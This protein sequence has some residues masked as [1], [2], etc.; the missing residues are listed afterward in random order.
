MSSI[1]AQWPCDSWIL[2]SGRS[3]AYFKSIKVGYDVS[4]VTYIQASTDSGIDFERG[5][6]KASDSMT[7]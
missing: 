1:G 5:F 4:G 6:L 7:I 3:Q 2:P